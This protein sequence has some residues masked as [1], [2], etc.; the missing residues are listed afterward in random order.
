MLSSFK[1][2][3]LLWTLAILVY[4]ANCFLLWLVNV[5]IITNQR[6][7]AAKY[8]TL[9]RKRIS[10]CALAQI[11]NIEITSKGILSGL[12]NFGN[13]VITPAGNPQAI[14]ISNIGN[15]MKL[16]N[17]IARILS[18]PSPAARGIKTAAAVPSSGTNL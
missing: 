10:D 11:A 7:I 16:K 5:C 1:G 4:L 12:F 15:P 6:V 2:W 18:R 13:L 9:L 14:E 3:L 17:Y 8:Q